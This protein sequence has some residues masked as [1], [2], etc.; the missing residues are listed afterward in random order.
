[1]N[2]NKIQKG[3]FQL[4]DTT[5]KIKIASDLIFN[6]PTHNEG[7]DD[8][9]AV[10]NNAEGD[11][12]A[13]EVI[14]NRNGT[15]TIK[16]KVTSKTDHFLGVTLGGQPISESPFVIDV[17]TGVDTMRIGPVLTWFSSSGVEA[18]MTVNDTFEPW[19]ICCN[20]KDDII[21][22]DH[23]NHKVLVCY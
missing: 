20:G 17:S 13:V 6:S 22:T 19:G 4:K 5:I 3:V 10:M 12:L 1:M 9:K 2:D 8:V 18:H 23:N 7:G 21:V 16:Y 15:Y 14:D 11:H